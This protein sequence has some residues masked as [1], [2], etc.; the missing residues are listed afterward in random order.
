VSRF[1]LIYAGAQKNIGPAGVSIVIVRDDLLQRGAL[2]ECPSVLD[3][4]QQADAQS[5]LNTPPCYAIYVVGLVMKW[6]KAQGG[7]EVMAARNAEKAALLYD[8][9]DAS[10]GFYTC[11]VERAC[12]SRMNVPFRVVGSGGNGASGG[13]D[14][15]LER[16]FLERAQAAR[17]LNLAGHRSVGGLRASLYNAM[18]LDGVRALVE[19]MRT[20]QLEH[21][22]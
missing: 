13:G 1:G 6:L 20:F 16:A 22:R 5:M 7:L 14:A 17:L 18:P 11:P 10:G 21:Q 4:K 19:L 12:R 15:A 9:I 2:K 3:L 8:A